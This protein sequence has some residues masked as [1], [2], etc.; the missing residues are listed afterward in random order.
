MANRI[1][2]YRYWYS[3]KMI[4]VGQIEFMTDGSYRVNGELVG[5]ILCESTGLKDK[6]GKEIYEGDIVKFKK[7]IGTYGIMAGVPTE[8]YAGK[9]TV[10]WHSPCFKFM[11]LSDFYAYRLDYAEVIGNIYENPELIK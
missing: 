7:G 3:V 4:E 5:G 10:E 8:L 1:I 9:A 6:N 11:G 2:K